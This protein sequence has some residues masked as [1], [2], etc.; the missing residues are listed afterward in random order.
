VITFAGSGIPA[1]INIPNYDDIRQD[2][3]FK[4]VSLGNVL[5]SRGGD[6][7]TTFLRDDDQALF[8]QLKVPA[9]EVQVGGHELLG[10]GSGKLFCVINSPTGNVKNFTENTLNPLT[11]QPVTT[12]YEVGQTY[13]H[14]FST[15]SSSFEECRAECVGLYLSSVPDFLRIFG[16]EDQ[17][18]QEDVMYVNWL[19]MARAGVVALECYSPENKQWRQAHMQA[20]FG[21]LQ[22]LLEAAGGL[23]NLTINQADATI[24][25]DRTKIVTVGVPAIKSFLQKLQIYKSIADIQSARELYHKYTDVNEKFLGLRTIVLAKKMPRPIF[26]QIHTALDENGQ[27]VLQEFPASFAGII[28][29]F[30]TRF[31]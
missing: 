26:V 4:N 19:S 11:E 6:V 12:C 23:V 9:F 22:V 31:T 3:G 16:Y 20:R 25:I 21:I 18:R 14:V 5:T 1:G 8:A 24:A 30:V 13:D 27:V 28:Q 17:K 2:E 10:H 7:K 15:L 29:S